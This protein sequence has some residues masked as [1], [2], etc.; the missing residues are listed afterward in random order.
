M[1]DRTP[2]MPFGSVPSTTQPVGPHE[3]E[4]TGQ[5]IVEQS[6]RLTSAIRERAV[7]TSD[8]KKSVVAEQVGSL[9]RKLESIANQGNGSEPA[10][11]DQLL[12]HGVDML[13]RVQRMLEDNSTEEL[14]RKAERQVKARPG[15]FIAGIGVL[16]FMAARL[17]RR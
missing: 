11:A 7:A 16:G 5:Q 2:T 1:H 4:G 17:I 8:D 12:D 15:L 14:L 3:S 13:R 6:R 9:V 10:L